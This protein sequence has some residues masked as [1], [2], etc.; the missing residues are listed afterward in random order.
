MTT[1]TNAF[2][3]NRVLD[4]PR[5]LVWKAH[6]EAGMLRHW[7]GPQGFNMKVHKMDLQPGGMFHFCLEGPDGSE[8]WAKFIFREIVPEQKLVFIMSFS[9]ANAGT[10]RYP[11]MPAW[12]LETLHTFTFEEQN[13]KT[14]VAMSAQPIF[15]T[16]EETAEF[17]SGFAG[18][19]EGFSGSYEQLEAYLISIA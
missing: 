19:N 18:M 12:P 3:L 7:W 6:T 5:S 4:A 13:G 14:L 8:L 9:D 17:E 10:A 11:M 2:T 15:A 1:Q 16:D